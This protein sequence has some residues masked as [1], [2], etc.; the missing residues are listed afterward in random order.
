MTTVCQEIIEG[1]GV[2][3]TTPDNFTIILHNSFCRT[4]TSVMER[5]VYADFVNNFSL[6]VEARSC[7]KVYNPEEMVSPYNCLSKAIHTACVFSMTEG[8]TALM[9]QNNEVL[10]LDC[11]HQG[12]KQQNCFY[13]YTP[14][15]QV[16]TVC[17]KNVEERC[18]GVVTPSNLTVLFE[19]FFCSESSKYLKNL[20]VVISR[21]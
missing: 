20:L 6:D 11:P 14:D 12:Q 21:W 5:Q 10:L 19:C 8:C 7:Y 17:Q 1:H 4:A 9:T 2:G 18:V 13:L 3:I 15:N 16:H